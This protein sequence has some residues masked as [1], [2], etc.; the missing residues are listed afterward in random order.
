MTK[1]GTA[2]EWTHIPGYKGESWNPI[3][4]LRNG[5]PGWHCEHVTEACRNCYAEAQNRN[6][7]NLA[8]GTGLGYK[9]GH[10]ADIDIVL[11]EKTLLAPLRWKKPRAI[12]VC[13]M[14]DLFGEWVTGAMLD[15][16]HAVMA[17]CPQHIWI[18]LTK[19][20]ERQREYLAFDDARQCVGWFAAPQIMT[21]HAPKWRGESVH[22][23]NRIRVASAGLFWPLPN[24]WRGVSVCD[25]DDANA[26]V[27]IL[28][29]T[30]A[31]IRFVSYEPAL[32]PVD[33]HDL[34]VEDNRPGEQ[35]F[36]A[37]ECDTDIADCAAEP[38]G[39]N[40]LDWIIAGGESGP[41]ARPAH[42]DWFRSARDQCQAAGVPFFFKQWGEWA[43]GEVAGPN[44]R[45]INAAT[46]FND[47]WIFQ[48]V[49]KAQPDDHR[50]DEPD[51]FRVGKTRAGRTLDGVE[52]SEFPEMSP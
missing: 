30:P 5:K 49:G 17:L 27:P 45:P 29:A 37:L 47:E 15:R 44:E 6:T 21:K 48:R 16:I 25:Q 4:A 43:P 11:D 51:M 42:P 34:V 50:D 26:F 19:R 9:P 31:A 24:V 35:H 41:N 38:W 22:G 10:R 20:P 18:V 12:F 13:S 7:R 2:I 40:V 1:H 14:T 36:S 46:W 3:R 52:H 28:L 39:T 23:Q 33:F 32:G 8:F